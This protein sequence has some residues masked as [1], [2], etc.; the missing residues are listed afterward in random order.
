MNSFCR[1]LILLALSLAP[2]LSSPG[3]SE[4]RAQTPPPGKSAKVL[5]LE[6]E[7]KEIRHEIDRVNEL[8][9]SAGASAKAQLDRLTLLRRQIDSR[10]Q[11]I[12]TLRAEVRA[13]DEEIKAAEKELDRLRRIFGQRQQSYVKSI[14]A[15]QHKTH[16][17]D[18]LLFILSAKDFAEGLRRARY[19]REYSSWQKQ[20]AEKLKALGLEIEQKKQALETARSEKAGLLQAGIDEQ[21]QLEEDEAKA[22]LQLK[23]LQS[24]EKE[25]RRQL[26]KNKRRAAE[27]NRQIEAQIRKEVEE[28]AKA[29]RAAELAR[30]K[31]LRKKGSSDKKSDSPAARDTRKAAAKGGYAMTEGE[32]K[33]SGSFA[34]NKGRLPA[35]LTGTF[36]VTSRFGAH[37]HEALSH[38]T[39]NNAG[40]DLR[41]SSSARAR[42][43]FDGKVT[44]IFT[45]EGFNNTIIV[46]HG[47]YL[48][49]Y[50]NLTEVSVTTGDNVRTG[51]DLGKIY[52]DPE[53]G[54]ASVLHF[55]VWK[56]TQKMDPLLW[57]KH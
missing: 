52:S 43:V 56:E 46:R 24:R 28:A 6:K 18:K 1:L 55:Q 25:L 35:P 40:V 9:G 31:A 41:G 10:R 22:A 50:S 47:N 54:G 3:V 13:A 12:E 19:L 15:L 57:I 51:Q 5:K 30:Q 42:A 27:L 26:D 2:A 4:L 32:A 37:R 29:A 14:R 7:R 45:L 38:V 36:T 44:R 49:I 34:S 23:E 53:L 21:K 16:A 33:L 8:L 11:L 20:E 17:K 39:V 48:T